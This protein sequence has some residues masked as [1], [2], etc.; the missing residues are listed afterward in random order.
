MVPTLVNEIG[1]WIDRFSQSLNRWESI[2][3]DL[4]NAT[5]RGDQDSIVELCRQ[6]EEMQD[7]ISVGKQCRVD[8]L[9]RAREHG[10]QASNIKEL[11]RLL[12]AAWPALWSHRIELMEQQLL[13][14]EQLSVSLWVTA[15]QSRD[16]VSDMI[17]IL[18]TGRA[19]EATY[20]PS[21]SN[22]REGGYLI[23]E[24]A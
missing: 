9:R 15:F 2:L 12:D 19:S 13:R 3:C 8:L 14:I 23:N 21:E 7:A 16:F 24:A 11:S 22:S 17:R 6:G 10:Y 1:L 5:L 20:C 18:S 4:R